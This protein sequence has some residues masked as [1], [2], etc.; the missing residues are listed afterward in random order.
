M[1]ITG[2]WKIKEALRFNDNYE[3]EWVSVESILADENTDPSDKRML[4]SKV[5]FDVDGFIKM[6][7]PVP[8]D[9]PQEEIDEALASG[10]LELYGDNMMVY[11]KYPYKTE[12]GK[13]MFRTNVRGEILGEEIDPWA[14]IKEADG[15]LEF[16]AYH[17][18]KE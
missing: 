12:D 2:I 17:L 3:R 4:G 15:I 13:L 1:D 10:E 8:E 6:M 14:E 9:I 5:L 7:M 11:E 18:E 16:F